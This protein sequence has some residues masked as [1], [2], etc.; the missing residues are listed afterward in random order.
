M[1]FIALVLNGGEKSASHHWRKS[2]WSALERKQW[3]PTSGMHTVLKRGMSVSAGNQTPNLR[4]TMQ[5]ND[6]P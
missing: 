2:P 1:C 3:S 6:S 5:L 4:V